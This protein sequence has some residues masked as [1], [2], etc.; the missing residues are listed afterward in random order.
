MRSLNEAVTYPTERDNWI[1]QILI[2]GFL[3]FLGFLLIPLFLVYGYIMVVIR[4]NLRGSNT[5]PVFENWSDLFVEGIQA[6]VIGLIYMLLPILIL[7]FAVGGAIVAFLTGTDAGVITGIG[8]IF[9][10]LLLSGILA[11]IL[12]YIAVAALVN[13][14]REQE[15]SAGFDFTTLRPVL[16]SS[17]YATA[18]LISIVILLVAAVIGGMLNAI[19][20]I[21]SFL[22]AIIG[23]YAFVVASVLWADGVT[24]ASQ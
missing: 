17:E 3:L 21:G 24:E 16:V 2:G 23:F 19:P 7:F 11:L 4:S 20:V 18:W 8:S 1:P 10:G 13:F 14:A 12:G 15:F 5:P 9:G 22:G 6:W